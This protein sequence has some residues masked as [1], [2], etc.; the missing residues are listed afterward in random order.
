MLNELPSKIQKAVNRYLPIETHGLVLWPVTV[1]EYE[2]FLIARAAL[3]VLHQSLPVAMMRV[4]LLSAYYQMDYEAR[5]AGKT[6]T[7]LFS[8]A[9]VGLALSLRLGEGEDLAERV[10]RFHIIVD[11]QHPA[12]LVKLLFADAD[13]NEKS[14]EPSAYREL[15]QIIAA[16]NGVE[17]E[18]DDANPDIVQAK[19]DMAA[20]SGPE[21]DF[22]TEALI[23]FAA[24]MTG[25]DEAD[26]YEWPILKLT[27]RTDTFQTVLSYLVCGIG[28]ASGSTWKNGNPVPHPIFK[29]REDGAGLASP[30]KSE[31]AEAK[32][33]IRSIESQLR[34]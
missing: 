8:C 15:R 28:E 4:P 30:L 14:I 17:L 21:L 16:Q 19:K 26:I 12:K 11:P 22:S 18:S 7:G 3:E 10:K 13:G 2:E 5:L 32:A 1:Q 27:R 29:R 6:M 25:T 31:N 9:L 24:A 33:G 20:G 34:Q 23:S